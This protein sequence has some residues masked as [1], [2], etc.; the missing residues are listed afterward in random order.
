MVAPDTI[1]GA[2]IGI[3][4]WD[5][6]NCAMVGAEVSYASGPLAVEGAYLVNSAE[7]GSFEATMIRIDVDYEVMPDLLINGYLSN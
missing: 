2:F 1:V 5:G 3:E 7:E 6:D 4:D